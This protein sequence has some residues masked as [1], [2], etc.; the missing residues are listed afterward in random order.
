VEGNL[1][2]VVF[3]STQHTSQLL[4]LAKRYEDHEPDLADLC[5]IRMSELYRDHVV[6]TVDEKDFRIYR[7][8][9]RESIPL[10]CPSGSPR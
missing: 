6:V 1:L 7:R 2:A 5:I 8:G 9:K 10:L 4:A 3:D